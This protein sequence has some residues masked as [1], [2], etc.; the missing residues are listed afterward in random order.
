MADITI[1]EEEILWQN[2]KNTSGDYMRPSPDS[3]VN[4]TAGQKWLFG[5]RTHEYHLGW[6]GRWAPVAVMWHMKYL[7]YLGKFKFCAA[8][9]YVDLTGAQIPRHSPKLVN[10]ILWLEEVDPP[11]LVGHRRLCIWWGSKG[12]NTHHEHWV[13]VKAAN[14]A[15][16]LPNIQSISVNQ[17]GSTKRSQLSDLVPN[18]SMVLQ[19]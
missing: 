12:P 19:A 2:Q 13:T 5:A 18:P 3:L 7:P 11:H 10:S 4:F 15:E 17:Q 16:G 14:L 6:E 9:P 1:F 8:G